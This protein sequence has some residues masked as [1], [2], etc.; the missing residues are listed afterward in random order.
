MTDSV[1]VFGRRPSPVARLGMGR[2]TKT[3]QARTRGDAAMVY[4]D[5]EF[6]LVGMMAKSAGRWNRRER[7]ERDCSPGEARIGI[8][9][10]LISG[11]FA[12]ILVKGVPGYIRRNG[13][14]AA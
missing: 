1:K 13:G 11:A 5:F 3:A 8:G 6:C 9:P 12:L 2:R 7:G 14:V 4:G 10:R